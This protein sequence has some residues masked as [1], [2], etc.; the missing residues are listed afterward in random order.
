MP[1]PEI[2]RARTHI[3]ALATEAMA[4]IGDDTDSPAAL[5]MTGVVNG[6][7]MAA[8]ILDGAG[9]EQAM[10]KLETGLA[11]IIGRMYLAGQMP[12][13]EAERSA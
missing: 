10:E 7:S 1:Q 12:A 3:K 4:A 8:Q 6:L 11:T 9:A 5:F 2:A 13:P